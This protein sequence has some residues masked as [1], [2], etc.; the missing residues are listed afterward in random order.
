M[1]ENNTINT[2]VRTIKAMVEL[3]N[4]ST[5]VEIFR[6][7]DKIK[8]IQVERVGEDSKFFGFGIC[9]KLS[10]HLIDVN[11]ELELTTD[12]SFKV[13]FDNGSGYIKTTPE[14][15]ITE[16]NRDEKT[17]ELSITAYDSIYKLTD[18]KV[19]DLDL[20]APYTIRDVISLCAVVV[21][22]NPVEIVRVGET[23]TCFSI[24]Y[25]SGANFEGTE[26]LRE[27]LNAAAEATQTIYYINSKN[28][29][30]FKRLDKDI[31][32][33]LTITKEDYIELKSSTNKRLGTIV[34]VTELGDNV[35]ASTSEAGSTQ[36]VRDNAF[37]ELREDIDTLV[38][39][40]LATVGGLTINQFECNWRGNYFLEIGD[41]IA[42]TTKD[43][44]TVISFVLDDVI[45]Y[46]GAYSQATKWSYSREDNPESS[47]S[48][49][50]G[51]SL[52]QTFAKVDKANKRIDLVVSEAESN[53]SKI[54][55]L[56]QTTNS[57]KASVTEIETINDKVEGMSEDVAQLTSKVNASITSE[58]VRIEIEK[59]LENGVSKVSTSTGVTV[60]ENGLT[61]DKANSEMKTTISDN[62]MTIRKNSEEVLVANNVGV[63]AKN[64]HATTYLIIGNNSRFEDYGTNRTGCFW[65]GGNS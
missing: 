14:F 37:W 16:V 21:N 7:E 58:Q 19:S 47:N 39:N 6:S 30:T 50:L 20:V 23:E 17:N 33:D 18:Y 4:G 13:Y 46:N 22:A 57:I 8:S 26:T 9:Q 65:I 2:P 10:L 38:E 5:L 15:F 44:D 24:S 1:I 28:K 3:Y 60:D 54:S 12:N 56:E 29:L 40:A 31:T 48:T 32:P 63:N 45:S 59:E 34:N 51:E 52:K 27:A 62:G 53:S 64:L 36:C 35:S 55:S 11:R 49:T 43:N 25:E 61:V 42:L 41:K